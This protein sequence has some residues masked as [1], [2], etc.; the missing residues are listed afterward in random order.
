MKF[1][2]KVRDHKR[3]AK[4]DFGFFR[5]GVMSCLLYREVGK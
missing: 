5:S 3:K 2:Y 1:V 4:F